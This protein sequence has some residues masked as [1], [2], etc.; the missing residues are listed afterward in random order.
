MHQINLLCSLFERTCSW[1]SRSLLTIVTTLT[2]PSSLR[3][4]QKIFEE[5]FYGQIFF[6]KVVPSVRFVPSELPLNK[7]FH[8][9]I[10]W[11][12]FDSFKCKIFY[13][14]S[15][16][17]WIASFLSTERSQEAYTCLSKFTSLQYYKAEFVS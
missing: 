2:T 8:K 9:V 10:G 12:L 13:I 17:Q 16:H 5:N 7:I 15:P 11:F 6:N 3:I 4:T 14:W 1:P